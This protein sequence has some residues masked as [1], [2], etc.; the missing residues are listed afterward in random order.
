MSKG[1]GV[2]EQHIPGTKKTRTVFREM[3]D[4]DDASEEVIR[5]G[6]FYYMK[7]LKFRA[8]KATLAK[9]K[10]GRVYIRRDKAGRRRRHVSSAPGQ[11]HANKG[12]DLRKSISWKVFGAK[13]AIFGYGVSTTA[14]NQAPIY[15][16]AIEYGHTWKNPKR[17][18]EARPTL[19][20]AVDDEPNE[21]HFDRAFDQEFGQ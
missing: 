2:R 6:F 17:V 7:A 21:V 13:G 20:N 5:R 10:R 14:K 18:L 8:N 16:G 15:A 9:D 1:F 19:S 11:S 12:G 4:L 3:E